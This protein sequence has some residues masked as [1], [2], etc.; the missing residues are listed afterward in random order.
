MVDLA[1]PS[2][3]ICHQHWPNESSAAETPIG[4]T[5]VEHLSLEMLNAFENLWIFV[6]MY[7]VMDMQKPVFVAENNK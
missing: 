4:L 2:L 1:G 7:V 6:V 3:E 5:K